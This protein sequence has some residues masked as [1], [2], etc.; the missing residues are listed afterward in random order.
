[1]VAVYTIVC[2]K[3]TDF[4]PR[5]YKSRGGRTETNVDLQRLHLYVICSKGDILFMEVYFVIHTLK[6]KL[7]SDFCRT[8][9]ALQ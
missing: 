1:M 8:P 6:P 3:N 2:Y 4:C 5:V 7:E 9:E